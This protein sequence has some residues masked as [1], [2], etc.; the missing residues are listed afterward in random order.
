MFQINPLWI[1]RG[2]GILLIVI[3]LAFIHHK[4]YQKGYDEAD[5]MW[6]AKVE[7]SNKLALETKIKEDNLHLKESQELQTKFNIAA[8]D[9][10]KELEI[11][12]EQIENLK[13]DVRN[14][15]LRLSIA[16]ATNKINS[17]K[18]DSN[19]GTASEFTSETANVMPEVAETVLSIAGDIAESVRERN[20]CIRLYNEV[21]EKINI[22]FQ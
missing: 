7:A 4:I 8:A 20:E 21:K 3:A 2:L 11:K 5:N 10:Q 15:N 19:S 14:G 13:R 16:V 9:H 12:N 1:L 22:E 17:S 6:K 18:S